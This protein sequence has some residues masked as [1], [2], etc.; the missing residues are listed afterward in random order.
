MIRRDISETA[1]ALWEHYPVL[2][3]TGPRQ[4]GKTTLAK[5]IFPEAGYVN[6]EGPEAH[7]LA[8]D[9]M[10]GFLAMHPAPVIFDEVQYAPELLRYIQAEVDATHPLMGNLFENMV[11][12]EILKNRRNYGE[13]NGIYHMRTSNGLEGMLS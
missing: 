3:I 10:K 6:L 1:R 2:T 12:M 13:S 9:D 11:V 5:H 7:A 4:S 8:L